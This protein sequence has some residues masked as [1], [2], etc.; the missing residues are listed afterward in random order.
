MAKCKVCG[1]E[2]PP[3]ERRTLSS[4]GAAS[5]VCR[6]L[7]DLLEHSPGAPSS[8]VC[9]GYL[10]QEPAVLCRPCFATAKKFADVREDV[11]LLKKR[12]TTTFQRV[13]NSVSQCNSAVFCMLPII[14]SH[15]VNVPMIAQGSSEQSCSIRKRPSESESIGPS[16]KRSNVAC[17]AINEVAK[18]KLSFPLCVEHNQQSQ[19][20]PSVT[21]STNSSFEHVH[22]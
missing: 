8:S 5:V 19:K 21:V 14:C 11:D 17:G 22:S 16:P 9:V 3:K 18:R 7:T 12:L 2:V 13:Q 4:G 20:S 15:Y 10:A 6:T 1:K